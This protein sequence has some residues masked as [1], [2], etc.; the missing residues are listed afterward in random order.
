MT[1]V[2]HTMVPQAAAGGGQVR[3]ADAGF[4]DTMSALKGAS[5]ANGPADQALGTVEEMI[6]FL[7]REFIHGARQVGEVEC[8]ERLDAER[9]LVNDATEAMAGSHLPQQIGAA[10]FGGFSKITGRRDPLDPRDIGTDLAEFDAVE[11]V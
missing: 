8:L 6:D 7:L 4:C 2:G 9:D 10:F 1:G 3:T 5:P 11:R